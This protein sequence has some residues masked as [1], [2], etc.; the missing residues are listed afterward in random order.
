M[1]LVQRTGVC[2][3]VAGG[4]AVAGQSAAGT[5][6]QVI[7]GHSAVHGLPGFVDCRARSA[8]Q[9]QAAVGAGPVVGSWPVPHGGF[10]AV[11]LG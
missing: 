5:I 1:A 2:R 8:G 7:A 10:A 4:P 6:P 3:D 11:V 9:G